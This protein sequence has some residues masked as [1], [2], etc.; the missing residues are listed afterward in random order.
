MI[1]ELK[2]YPELRNC[3]VAFAPVFP[4]ACAGCRTQMN[5]RGD[6]MHNPEYGY[7]CNCLSRPTAV[8]GSFK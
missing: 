6:R 7:G 3:G 2:R 8:A 1:T 4:D 5:P